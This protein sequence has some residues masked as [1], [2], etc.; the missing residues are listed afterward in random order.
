M[1][2]LNSIFM[3]GHVTDKPKVEETEGSPALSFTLDNKVMAFDETKKEYEE[4]HCLFP[5]VLFGKQAEQLK[6][7]MKKGNRV[8]VNGRLQMLDK[9]PRI[10]AYTIQFLDTK[11]AEVDA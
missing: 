3:V 7:H 6:T 8:G 10:I 9:A 2:D 1:N 11:P 5:V 4:E